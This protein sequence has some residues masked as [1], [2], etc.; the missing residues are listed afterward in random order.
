MSAALCRSGTQHHPGSRWRAIV[1]YLWRRVPDGG[2]SN[3]FHSPMLDPNE[4]SFLG[5]DSILAMRCV[6][7]NSRGDRL[8]NRRLAILLRAY[9]HVP[10]MPG[11]LVA[12]ARK[13]AF[14]P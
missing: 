14:R 2:L 7:R 6:T 11:P 8:R 3:R 4:L 13:V 1:G 5:H 12:L 10:A 9:A